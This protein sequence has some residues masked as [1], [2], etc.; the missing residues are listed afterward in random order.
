MHIGYF[1]SIM[2]TTGGPAIVDKE[3]LEAISQFDHKNNYTVY[4][5]TPTSTQ[6]LRLDNSKQNFKIKTI[7]PS[8]KWWGISFG[9]SWELF[10]RP[11]DLLH[12]TIIAPPIVPC[13]F[14]LTITCWSQYSQ[15]ELYPPLIRLRL[16]YL[17]NK[18]IPKA[19]AFFCYTEYL[20]NKM[21]ERFNCNP[22][23][24]FLIQPAVS[25]EIKPVNDKQ[26]LE[27]FLTKSSIHWPY[28]LFVGSI[29]K[30]KNIEGLIRAYHILVNESKIEHKL[31]LLGEKLYYSSDIFKIVE[32]I[33]LVDRVVFIDRHP[34]HQL[35]FFYSGA[36]VFVFPTYSEG[37]GLP[38]LEAMACGTPV[39]ASNTTSVP[40]V[41]G[42]AAVLV[43]PHRPEDIASGIYK[44]LTDNDLRDNL[45]QRG[46]TRA[47]EFTWDRAAI[48]TITAYET[49]FK[50]GW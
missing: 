50:A 44:C 24:I 5:L 45:I 8:G 47:S 13:K 32:K 2:G 19:S 1:S 39:V 27:N 12:A 33:N 16:L 38:P 6:G 46:K 26:E 29:T 43:D 3:V 11:V 25:D 49:I 35:P 36:D 30:R 9:L 48:Q 21:I 28:I 18:A 15:P 4:G 42:N 23:R 14:V 41:V 40:E 20:K 31:V 17:L 37:F 10:R 7:K 22:E 34:H